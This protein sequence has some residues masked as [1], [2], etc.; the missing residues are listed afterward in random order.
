MQAYRVVAARLEHHLD[1]M[2]AVGDSPLERI[3]KLTKGLTVAH[4]IVKHL[5]CK[6]PKHHKSAQALVPAMQLC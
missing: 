6:E 1:K 3:N 4:R 2:A 5:P